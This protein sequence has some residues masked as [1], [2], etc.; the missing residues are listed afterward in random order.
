M[1]DENVEIV[2]RVYDGWARGDFSNVDDFDPDIEFAMADWP[3][4]TTVRGIPQMWET[5]RSTLSAWTDFRAT[6]SEILDL[7]DRVLATNRIDGRGKESGAAVSADV[8][9][10]FTL[11]DGKVVRM[12]LYWDV[13]SA[14]REAETG[15]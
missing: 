15:V 6:P 5:W 14:R 3:H 4:Q 7:G 10:V 8:A 1:S 9:T 12:A 13:D 2:R 11:E